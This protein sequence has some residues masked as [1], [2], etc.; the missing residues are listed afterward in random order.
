MKN[1]QCRIRGIINIPHMLLGYMKTLTLSPC[2]I[3]KKSAIKYAYQNPTKT[4]NKLI[5]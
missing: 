3:K 5:K 4:M 2:L 1:R